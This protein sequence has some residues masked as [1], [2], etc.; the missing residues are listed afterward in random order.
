ME[1]AVKI[2]KCLINGS[3]CHELLDMLREITDKNMLAQLNEFFLEQYNQ[4]PNEYISEKFQV[5]EV[6]AIDST[7]KYIRQPNDKNRQSMNKHCE[8]IGYSIRS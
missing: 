2:H 5:E 6:Y 1:L 3:G 4:T 7:L 8:T